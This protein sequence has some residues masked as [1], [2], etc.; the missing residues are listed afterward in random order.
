MVLR[1]KGLK[2][3]AREIAES[4]VAVTQPQQA[5]IRIRKT[6]RR[7]SC[8]RRKWEESKGIYMYQCALK[9]FI[10]EYAINWWRLVV[11]QLSTVSL[12]KHVDGTVSDPS[13][14]P[15]RHWGATSIKYR[16]NVSG[17]TDL[18]S[19]LRSSSAPPP[20]TT[21]QAIRQIIQNQTTCMACKIPSQFGS[22]RWLTAGNY[23][24]STKQREEYYPRSL[25]IE[26]IAFW[27][28]LDFEETRSIGVGR[29]NDNENVENVPGNEPRD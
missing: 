18:P 13:C 7:S 21:R 27:C 15:H 4:N 9:G 11:P 10:Q 5:D 26:K 8:E 14:P 23:L 17:V 1:A 6:D 3:C 22:G 16:N 20:R 19:S 12:D 24:Q 28:P 2:H 29:P 25:S